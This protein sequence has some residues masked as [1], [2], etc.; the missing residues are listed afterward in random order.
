MK[1]RMEM[2]MEIKI[3]TRKVNVQ[4][5]LIVGSLHNTQKRLSKILF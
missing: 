3:K 4:Y 5:D 2:R 1:A